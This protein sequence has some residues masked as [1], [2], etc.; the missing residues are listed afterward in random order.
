MQHRMEQMIRESYPAID[1]DG[2]GLIKDFQANITLKP[3]A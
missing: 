3:N 1:S 2:V